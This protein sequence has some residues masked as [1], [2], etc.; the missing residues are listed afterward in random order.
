MP[1]YQRNKSMRNVNQ[2]FRMNNGPKKWVYLEPEDTKTGFGR[3]MI[4]IDLQEES[5]GIMLLAAVV[6]GVQIYNHETNPLT[7]FCLALIVVRL[8]LAIRV[9]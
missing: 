1:N 4:T 2:P 5:L 6:A 8:L 3:S 7:W 9:K